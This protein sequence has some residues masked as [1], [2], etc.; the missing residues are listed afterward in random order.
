MSLIVT[1]TIGIDTVHTP[2]ASAE[3]VLGGSCS[4]FSAAASF[5]GPVR[6]VA[7]V[8]GDWPD[9]HRDVLRSFANICTEGLEV[10]P[11]SRTFAWGGRYHENMN[12]RETLFTEL[13]VLEEPPPKVPAKYRD[14]R[15]VFLGNTHPAVQ[16]DLLR[17][18]PERSL[19]VA[20]TMDLWINVARGELLALLREIDG[21]VLNDAEAELFTETRNP[22]SAARK[23]LALGPRFVVVKKGEHGAI[24]V[25][26][27]GVA[28]VPAFPAEAHQVVDPTGAGDSFAGGM[29]GHLASAGRSDLPAIQ[30]AL[31]WGTVVASFTIESHGLERLRGLGRSD[32]AARMEEFRRIAS[33]GER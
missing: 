22:V 16:L 23:I 24:L 33:V 21:L 20:D 1:G 3:R 25:H 17:Q 12:H 15:Y 30:S 31:A 5:F 26:R 4:Y 11:A 19:A 9:A 6:M 14:S 2:T 29:M 28:A 7:A 10:R 27:D 32:V 18:L 8:G 13:G